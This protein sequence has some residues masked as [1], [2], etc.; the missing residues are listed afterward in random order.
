[1]DAYYGTA[2]PLVV[3]A[4]RGLEVLHGSAV[5]VPS[6]SCVV[7]F[8]GVSASG[9]STVAYGLGGRG[10]RQW[11]D[12]AVAF[13]ADGSRP[14]AAVGLPFTVK[15]LE[16]S[17]AYFR[18]LGVDDD[19]PPGA[20]EDFQWTLARLGA[21]FLLEPLDRTPSGKTALQVERLEPGEALHALLPN[22]FRF[23]PQAVERRRETM[24]SYLELVASVPIFC[25]RFSRRF[26]RLPKVLD[27]F[28]QRMREIA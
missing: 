18:A 20:V 28:E 10:Y 17:S 1:M 3:Q 8:C 16:S 6:Q 24:R 4:T 13:R 23:Q 11:A 22:A 9:K 19:L 26:D 14:S 7:A 27:E 25:A 2:M 15:L 5:L 12:D 21:V